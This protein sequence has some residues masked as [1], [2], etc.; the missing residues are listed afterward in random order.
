MDTMSPSAG[1]VVAAHLRSQIDAF[2]ERALQVADHEPE[3][4]HKM[5]V[6]SRQLRSALSTFHDLLNRDVTDPVRDEL[7]W[8]AGL[9]G[10]ARDA[11]VI[12][13]RLTGAA[14]D[15][16]VDVLP[17]EVGGRIERAQ[18]DAKADA[19]RLI[20][21]AM[22]T[23]RYTAL[24]GSLD[25]LAAEPPLTDPADADADADDGLRKPVRRRWRQ[26]KRAVVAVDEAEDSE[27]ALHEVRKAAKR[28]RYACE[29]VTSE[30]GDDA[31]QTA[32]LAESI[33]GALGEQQDSIH[34]RA[35]LLH[36]S[37]DATAAGANAF[38]FG[39]LYAREEAAAASA[40]DDAMSY[41]R[42]LRKHRHRAWFTS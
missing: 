2:H 42:Q 15:V 16:D 25:A 10:V 23:P 6:A 8:F 11:E 32:A 14:E 38:G 18:A 26:L 13:L 22:T 37:V 21:E 9:L 17:A 29:S 5:R 31:A 7:K 12:R 3:G 41:W 27:S 4:V 20:D 35:Y 1:D 39:Y 30:F 36:A 24:V 33:Q 40:V 34:A 19:H 28:L